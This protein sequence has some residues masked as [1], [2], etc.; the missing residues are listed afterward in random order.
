M[1]NRNTGIVAAMVL[2]ALA[3]I[4]VGS[5]FA[6]PD[7]SLPWSVFGSGGG[8]VGS[9][10]YHADATLGQAGPIGPASSASY[11]LGAG[12]WYGECADFDA[13]AACDSQDVEDDGD[14]FTDTVESGEPLCNGT[15][16][17]SFDD[18]VIDD[19]CS[20]GPDQAGAFSEA[21]FKIGTGAS[22]PCGNN[23]WPLELVTTPSG[24]A[25]RYNISDL[26]S[27]VAPIRR[28]G[29]NPNQTGF[30]S[31]WDFQPGPGALPTQGWINILDLGATT[32]SSTGFPRMLGGLRAIGQLCP[33]PP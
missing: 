21:E 23:G 28:I 6:A 27:F 33:Y 12:F 9:T 19:G 25:N 2:L 5:L 16:H 14:G 24:T 1:R 22:D 7:T 3:S 20:G 15:N 17:D 26:G 11:N 29:K 8:A 10:N 30:S 31:R 13:D 4:S 32:S 18:S